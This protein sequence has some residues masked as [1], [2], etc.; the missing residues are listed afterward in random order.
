MA[1]YEQRRLLEQLMGE[2]FSTGASSEPQVS[3]TD[4]I[5]CR[6]YLV[7]TCPQDRF[8]NTKSDLGHCRERH[9]SSLKKQYQEASTAEKETWGFE[10]DYLNK[11]R[12]L[13]ADCD[14]RIDSHQRRL[15]KTPDEIRKTKELHA[16][17]GELTKQIDYG[18]EE[19][20]V[21]I[22]KNN[23]PQALTLYCS[24][25]AFRVEKGKLEQELKE[26][27]ETSGPSGHQKLTV[28]DVCGAYLSRLDNDRRLA[29]H[30]LGKLHVGYRDMRK[31]CKELEEQL[32][33]RVPPQRQYDE[34]RYNA[35]GGGSRRGG[36]S[37]AG[38]GG[39]RR[40]GRGRW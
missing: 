4:P 23:V 1:R 15:E 18:V 5:V 17:I 37:Y 29:D 16:Q 25:D 20:K 21:F 9:I 3:I 34:A 40:R 24:L 8:T 27:Q 38:A 14:N 30:F 26:L 32:K 33:D 11:M 39:N 19:V 6:A 7:G 12:G 28:C 13:L 31:E 10:F 36:Q 22:S 2:N 35:Y